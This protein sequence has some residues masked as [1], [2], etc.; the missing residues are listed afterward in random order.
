[1][2]IDKEKLISLL[3]EKTG[4]EQEQVEKQ[5][6]ELINRIQKAADDGKDFEIE[7][8]GVFHMEDNGLQ[9][10]PSKT[11]ET[12]INNKYTGMR[13]IELI[14][15][16]KKPED[17]EIP[18]ISEPIDSEEGI[19]AFDEEAEKEV[20]TSESTAHEQEPDI[21]D[22]SEIPKKE[23]TKEKKEPVTDK[24]TQPKGE[25]HPTTAEN[26]DKKSLETEQKKEK[27]NIEKSI[28][29][30]KSEKDPIG[31]VL[32]VAVVLIVIGVSGWLVYDMVL[33][34]NNTNAGNQ[35][36]A[37]EQVKR[38]LP[39][40]QTAETQDEPQNVE[41]SN[42][43]NPSDKNS[44]PQTESKVTKKEDSPSESQQGDNK[45]Y[46]LRGNINHSIKSGY[47]IVVHS[48]KSKRQAEANMKILQNEGYRT[49]ISEA[50]VNGSMHYRVSIG[51]FPT[52]KAAQE[53]TSTLSEPYRS[54]N[55]IKRIK[56]Q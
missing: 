6:S 32:V 27:Q 18:D 36:F 52:I 9:F 37:N 13:P 23:E 43:F 40:H 10:E 44:E 54:N 33:G 25:T 34:K 20:S 30:N 55:F 41:A 11:L 50:V 3:V 31:R 8:F 17:G 35:T 38:P 39:A 42:N 14:G 26:Q 24:N 19:W 4:L 45:T 46:G 7:G 29:S 28:A 2:I 15:A 16:F 56:Q 12:E 53:A 51:Q 49:L 21:N 48:L 22:K 1:M 47:T 5:L